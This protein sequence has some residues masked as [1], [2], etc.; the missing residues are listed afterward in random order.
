MA[1]CQMFRLSC[2]QHILMWIYWRMRRK[3]LIKSTVQNKT[4]VSFDEVLNKIALCTELKFSSSC[5]FANVSVQHFLGIAALGSRV[6]DITGNVMSCSRFIPFTLNI[7]VLLLLTEFW[8]ESSKQNFSFAWNC[9]LRLHA[10]EVGWSLTAVQ[11]WYRQNHWTVGGCPSL[12][13][14]KEQNYS[15]SQK[16]ET[17][18]KED[19][20]TWAR[21][22]ATRVR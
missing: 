22:E 18:H 13:H 19:T 2:L 4:H 16:R 15:F 9:T 11:W 1:G 5:S 17:R 7:A 20:T 14:P 10:F 8:P 12:S 21:V 6:R 3:F